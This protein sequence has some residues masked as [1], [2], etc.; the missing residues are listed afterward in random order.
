MEIRSSKRRENIYQNTNSV[1]HPFASRSLPP[2]PDI[3]PNEYVE[4]TSVAP[5]ANLAPPS[6]LTPPAILT[7]PTNLWLPAYLAPSTNLGPTAI[8]TPPS[9]SPQSES[10]Y[11]NQHDITLEVQSE[12]NNEE[13]YDNERSDERNVNERS[14][15]GNVN[16]RSNAGNVNERSNAGNDNERS[17][18][19]NYNERS[20]EGN[21][22]LQ[23][24]T[25]EWEAAHARKMLLYDIAI[26]VLV[27]AILALLWVLVALFLLK[28][29]PVHSTSDLSHGRNN[30]LYP[31]DDSS[32]WTRLKS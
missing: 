19:R 5:P 26:T 2:I 21:Y 8:L 29:N 25:Q 20:D 32:I 23:C 12:A 4:M 11:I 27:V 3:V 22:D 15:A 10:L 14:N 13:R 30:K 9:S 7:P 18:E 17:N 24:D 1:P 6:I 16:E 31:T 28:N